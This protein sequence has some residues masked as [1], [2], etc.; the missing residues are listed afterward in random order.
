M[1]REDRAERRARC[2]P[3]RHNITETFST[4]KAAQ[5]RRTQSR[6]RRLCC[7]CDPS[8]ALNLQAHIECT[9]RTHRL[10]RYRPVGCSCGA[11]H[12]SGRGCISGSG[13]KSDC[14]RRRRKKTRCKCRNAPAFSHLWFPHFLFSSKLSS[15]FKRT[16][17]SSG[18]PA[19]SQKTK[20]TFYPRQ[21]ASDYT[22]LLVRCVKVDACPSCTGVS[23]RGAEPLRCTRAFLPVTPNVTHSQRKRAFLATRK[24]HTNVQN[25][26]ED[27]R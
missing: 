2:C 17:R 1:C 26:C 22:S 24:L 13:R 11:A 27:G 16:S 3:S 10:W 15:S 7:F 21:S 23:V 25:T 8:T 9:T 4:G 19:L 20:T 18:N 14:K 6:G 12:L 5:V